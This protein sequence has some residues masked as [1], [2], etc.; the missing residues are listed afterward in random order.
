MTML[1]KR[2]TIAAS[3]AVCYAACPAQAQNYPDKPIRV[4]TA[5]GGGGLDM[6]L[7]T[8][9][10]AIAPSL[11]QRFIVENR[12]S[13]TRPE[14]VVLKAPADGYTLIYWANPLWLSP[15]LME[16]NYDPIRDFAP[17]S[18]V[19]QVPTVMVVHPSMPVKT[20]KELVALAKKH[21]GE[22]NLSSTSN[23]SSS[24]AL[25]GMLF[26]SY[27]GTDLTEIF[28]KDTGQT[29]TDLVAGRVHVGFPSLAGTLPHIKSGRLRALGVSTAQPSPQLP[30]VPPLRTLYPDFVS[31]SVHGF[32]AG[33]NTAPAI[34]NRLNQ[35]VVRAVREPSLRDTFF[36]MG[37][38][39]VGSTP[40]QLTA[41]VRNEMRTSGKLIKEKGIRAE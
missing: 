20:V 27:S 15:F 36:G 7:R 6:A 3:L 11:G 16:V 8:L 9:S 31:A 18:L 4:V 24:N 35:E 34:I 38:E 40:E 28:Y 32:F 37:I 33:A 23:R 5:G 30:D 12:A 21:P 29:I 2:F 14:Q 10:Q 19:A 17:I 26:Q 39:P 41:Y 22:L 1:S 25:A 13:S